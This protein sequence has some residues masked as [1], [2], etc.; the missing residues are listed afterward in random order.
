MQNISMASKH[1]G[2]MKESRAEAFL[3]CAYNIKKLAANNLFSQGIFNM[4][5]FYVAKCKL[6]GI[7]YIKRSSLSLSVLSTLKL[8]IDTSFTSTINILLWHGQIRIL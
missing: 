1:R 5:N 7:E 2:L 4:K 3:P 6:E 8:F